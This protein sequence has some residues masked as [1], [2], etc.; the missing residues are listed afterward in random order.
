N[1]DRTAPL[2]DGA[3]GP[4]GTYRPLRHRGEG[5]TATLSSNRARIFAESRPPRRHAAGRETVSV[6]VD[7][8]EQRVPLRTTR[9]SGD[10]IHFQACP[11]P[12]GGLWHRAAGA[13]QGPT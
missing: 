7:A 6:I 4:G 1:P 11:D 8:P 3:R 12:G 5:I 9:I 13:P 10:R 2:P